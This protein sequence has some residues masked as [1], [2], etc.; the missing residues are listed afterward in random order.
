MPF[1]QAAGP[2]ALPRTPGYFCQDKGNDIL[3][4]SPDV[5]DAEQGGIPMAVQGKGAAS[6][7]CKRPEA[8]RPTMD[9]RSV[10]IL[11]PNIPAGGSHIYHLTKALGAR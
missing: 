4:I 6:P 2:G 11:A 7:P 3:T 9:V 10:F 8:R 5:G 1:S